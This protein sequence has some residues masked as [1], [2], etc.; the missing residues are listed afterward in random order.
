M[1]TK[2][3]WNLFIGCLWMVEVV[4]TNFS[5]RF[6]FKFRSICT[7]PKLWRHVT[8]N[9]KLLQAVQKA[10]FMR[11]KCRKLH[12]NRL[13]NGEDT[14]TWTNRTSQQTARAWQSMTNKQKNSSFSFSCRRTFIDLRQTL[15]A[16]R[17][18]QYNFCR[19]R[20]FL[21]TIPSFW[22]KTLF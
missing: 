8:T 17:G 6:F 5:T 13:I 16:D 11:W 18:H 15:H 14:R 7:P 3:W 9:F 12:G 21:A 2:C 19:K 10:V 20:L 4:S 1:A 22:V